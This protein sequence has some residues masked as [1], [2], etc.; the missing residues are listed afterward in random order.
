MRGRV[1]MPFLL[2]FVSFSAYSQTAKIS[3]WPHLIEANKRDAAQKLC[4]SFVDSPKINEKVEAQK[5][6]ANVALM[7]NDIVLL[8]GNDAGGGE[9]RSGYTKEAADAALAH[10]DIALKLA[11]QDLSIHQGRLHILEVAGRYSDM[12]KALD[13]SCTIY[14]GTNAV[15]AWLPYVGELNDMQQYQAAIDFSKVLD[16]HYPNNPDVVGN[17][18]AFLSILGRFTEAIPYLQRAASLAPTDPINAWDLGR[19]YDYANQNELANR[20]Y[21]K[22]LALLT[23]KK[24]LA[25]S[26]CLYGQFLDKKLHDRERACSLEKNNCA[27]NEQS[28]CGNQNA[29]VEK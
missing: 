21:Q 6:L 12:I 19:A 28:A 20:W 29:K 4:S 27:P 13:Q 15:D 18:G 23:D 10:L 3:D 9:I 7:G 11:P 2:A 17:I 25:G 1:L 14:K 22:G 24:Q 5:C 26:T 8:E 16:K